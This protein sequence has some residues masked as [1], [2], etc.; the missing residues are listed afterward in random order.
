M[1]A[2]A[3]ITDTTVAWPGWDQV[4]R[5]LTL[6]DH[7]TRVVVLGTMLLGLAAGIVGTYMLLRRR[8]LIG[9]ALSHS[10]LPGIAIAF[11]VMVQ[12]GGTGKS[13]PGLLLGA[14]LTG[15]LGVGA[16]LAI[17]GWS[18][19]KEDAALGIVLSVLFGLGIALLGVIQKMPSGGQAGLESFI[20][21]MTASMLRSDAILIGVTAFGVIVICTLLYKE[22]AILSFDPAYD[23]DAHHPRRRRPL[24][25]EPPAGDAR[26][27]RSHRGGQ[28]IP[29]RGAERA[30]AAASHGGDHR[31][32]GGG[33]LRRQHAHR[34]APRRAAA[35]PR[36]SAIAV[37]RAP[38]APAAGDLRVGGD[39]G[40][41]GPR[42]EAA[43]SAQAPPRGPI[44]VAARPRPHHPARDAGGPRG[45]GGRRR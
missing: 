3:S 31:A 42:L 32:R 22:F 18:R 2:H 14:T 5:V 37:A 33:H 10:T 43:D 16:I 9:D 20:Y 26:H 4:V 29:R 12:L 1:S 6:S 40:D 41:A 36:A 30:R 24:L 35:Q 38:P 19:V 44:L 11:I 17:K 13:L 23:R 8:A 45:T 25:D 7:T 15:L 28:R 39:D 34:S 27:V 21:G